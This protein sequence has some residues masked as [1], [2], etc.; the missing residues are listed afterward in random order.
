MS[1]HALCSDRFCLSTAGARPN[2]AWLPDLVASGR[3]I[4][5]G[6]DA[7]PVGDGMAAALI[8][9]YPPV[10]R[11]RPPAQDWNDVVRTRSAPSADYQVGGLTEGT[12]FR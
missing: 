6:Y 9:R 2:A 5:R 10:R 11:M 7:D 12:R 4:S 1:C 8:A 3:E